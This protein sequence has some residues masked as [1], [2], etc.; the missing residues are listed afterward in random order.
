MGERITKDLVIKAMKMAIK[1][2]RPNPGLIFYSDRGSQ[3]CSNAYQKLLES[4]NITSSMSC[5]GNPY[6]NAVAENFFSNIKCECT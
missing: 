2:E 4:N 6:D 1:S 5:K 3:Y